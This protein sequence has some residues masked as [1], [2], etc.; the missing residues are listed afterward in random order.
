[1][2]GRV[3]APLAGVG[4][5]ALARALVSTPP[6]QPAGG[7][8]EAT[9][10]LAF[11]AVA[12]EESTMRREA[13]KTF[14]TDPWSRDDAFHEKEL[15]RARDWAGKHRVRLGDVLGAVDDGLHAHWPQDNH[16]PLIPTVPP[17]RPRAIY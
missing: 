1:V 3:W 15:S 7:I 9:R 13:A 6:E 14:P 2:K 16:A 4:A 5:I 17:C 11:R 8:D 10:R 12:S